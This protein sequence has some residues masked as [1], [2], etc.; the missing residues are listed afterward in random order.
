MTDAGSSRRRTLLTVVNKGLPRS[1]YRL[2][3]GRLST[4]WT[5]RFGLPERPD[6]VSADSYD[7]VRFKEGMGGRQL[8]GVADL[9]E[10]LQVETRKATV[11][12]FCSTPAML[13]GPWIARVRGVPCIM[14]VTG[15]GR[16]FDWEGPIGHA[17]RWFYWRL[18]TASVRACERVLFQN[19]GH[20]SL[21]RDRMPAESHKFR[22]V[23]SAVDFPRVAPRERHRPTALMVGRIMP[24]KGVEDF[25][26]V[27]EALHGEARFRLI[28]PASTGYEG[29]LKRVK[30][31]DARGVLEYGGEINDPRDLEYEF[32]QSDIFLFPSVGEGMSRAMLEA[33]FS[34]LCPVGYSI[35]A[36]VDLVSADR[37]VLVRLGDAAALEEATR[38]VI[39]NPL[40]RKRMA[41]KYQD[42]VCDAFSVQAYTERLE[43]ALEPLGLSPHL[44]EDQRA[45]FSSPPGDL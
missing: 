21:F 29:F 24:S 26:R 4:R 18:M 27:A 31:A 41:K 37:G 16:V 2:A 11:V 32:L 34:G 8:L 33:G 30:E 35:P 14:T 19:S 9:L 12:H 40:D 10:V 22:L 17:A 44:G 15:L 28:G 20:L 39:R 42:F 45:L 7:R 5:A 38:F 3:F 23:G 36:N 43:A 13:L 1:D 25:I 6:W